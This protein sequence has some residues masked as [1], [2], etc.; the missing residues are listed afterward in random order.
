MGQLSVVARCRIAAH[1][2]EK[3]AARFIFSGERA[4]TAFK[5]SFAVEGLPALRGLS[6]HIR[7]GLG[8][9]VEIKR[10][11]ANTGLPKPL[12]QVCSIHRSFLHDRHRH[13]I[14]SIIP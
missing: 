3:E 13:A 4:A 11:W 12:M 1:P 2:V 6:Q 5:A 7:V 14:H 8:V 10:T 9:A